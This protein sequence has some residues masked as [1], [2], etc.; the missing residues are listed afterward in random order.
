MKTL[1]SSC[2]DSA[3]PLTPLAVAVASAL[4]SVAVPA[5]GQEE[6][7]LEEVL[8]TATRRAETDIQ[9]T[10][11]AVTQVSAEQ[12]QRAVPRDLLDVA[13][14]APN[15]SAGKQPGFNL[16]ASLQPPIEQLF[17]TQVMGLRT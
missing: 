6:A 2:G 14:Y 4:L 15:V 9:S 16:C 11:I 1:T 8:V 17:K 12:I 3:L 5:S 7:R 13:K 10:P